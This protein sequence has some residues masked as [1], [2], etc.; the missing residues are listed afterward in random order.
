MRRKRNGNIGNLEIQMREKKMWK[1]I[2]QIIMKTMKM[3]LKL[4]VLGMING[5]A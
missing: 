4:L 3:E 2:N 1:D 5:H